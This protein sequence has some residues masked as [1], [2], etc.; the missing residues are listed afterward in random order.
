[1][2]VDGGRDVLDFGVGMF[3]VGF[4]FVGISDGSD[5]DI[6]TSPQT[7]IVAIFQPHFNP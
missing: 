3:E 4:K 5:S 7:L 1:M 6:T 2:V